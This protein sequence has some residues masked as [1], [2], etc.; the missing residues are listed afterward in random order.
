MK[1]F[2]NFSFRYVVDETQAVARLYDAVCTP[3]VFGF[4]SLEL[5]IVAGLEH[6]VDRRRSKE[7]A[8]GEI[9]QSDRLFGVVQRMKSHDDDGR[10]DLGKML[11]P[12]PRHPQ[13][14][15]PSSGSHHTP[16]PLQAPASPSVRIARKA[17]TT[18]SKDRHS[19]IAL[20]A[21]GLAP[22]AYLPPPLSSG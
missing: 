13:N 16:C 10:G 19:A 8:T 15:G 17:A 2:A 5:Q 20:R 1:P 4:N 12:P 11:T 22:F 3:D 18:S 6:H 7:G 14:W 9:P 21:G